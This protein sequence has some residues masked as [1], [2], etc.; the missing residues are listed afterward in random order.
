MVK[1]AYCPECE[2]AYRFHLK[3]RL[4]CP[5]CRES[6][7][8][9]DVPRTKYFLIQF[10]FVIVGFIIICFSVFY[11]VI[12]QDR[13]VEPFGLFILGFALLLFALAIQFTDNAKMEQKGTELGRERYATKTEK[14][15]VVADRFKPA[16]IGISMSMNDTDS[17]YEQ[18]KLNLQEQKEDGSV[19]ISQLFVK[20]NKPVIEKEDRSVTAAKLFTRPNK[21]DR[22][23][24]VPKQDVQETQTPTKIQTSQKVKISSIIK[25]QEGKKKARKIRKAI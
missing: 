17:K 3:K 19:S 9:I 4:V 1:L 23:I 20:P 8:T 5:S 14:D 25:T 12:E 6:Y 13:M 11:L 15:R 7:E 18:T 10:P 22:I 21:A 2:K 16:S 24:R